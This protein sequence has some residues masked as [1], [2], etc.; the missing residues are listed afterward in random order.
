LPA[1]SEHPTSSE[2]AELL[3][4]N[5]SGRDVVDVMIDGDFYVKDRQIMTMAEEDIIEA[6]RKTRDKC[7]PN[8]AT[9]PLHLEVEQAANL[10]LVS[11]KSKII[12]LVPK[13]NVAQPEGFEEGFSVVQESAPGNTDRTITSQNPPPSSPSGKKKI[14]ML[15][16]LPKDVRRVFGEDEELSPP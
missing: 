13:G 1:I 10:H 11:S 6:F 4:N 2:L 3:I 14:V 16:E 15:P 9:K 7:F 5:L 8:S 12:P